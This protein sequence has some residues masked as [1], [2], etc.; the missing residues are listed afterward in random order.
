M[1]IA[2]EYSAEERE[3]MLKKMREASNTF[4]RL[5]VQ[6]GCHALIEFTGLQNEFITVCETAHKRGQDF[7]FANTHGGKPMPFGPHNLRY[8]AEKLNCIYGPS[9]LANEAN[10]R[11][12]VE[13]LFEGEYE[14]V[15]TNH[16]DRERR[17]GTGDA[18]S[19]R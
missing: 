12:F 19:Y 3:D 14:L 2:T 1:E 10:R 18:G 7:P 8:L 17:D 4:Y 15:R 6:S 11:A 16:E 9:L 5:A 13:T